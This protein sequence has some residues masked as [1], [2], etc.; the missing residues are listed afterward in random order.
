LQQGKK[1]TIVCY[2]PEWLRGFFTQFIDVGKVEFI[3]ELPK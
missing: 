1:V 3:P 2:E